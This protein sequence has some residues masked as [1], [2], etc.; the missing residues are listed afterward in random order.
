MKVLAALLLSLSLPGSHLASPPRSPVDRPRT[1]Q[2][3]KGGRWYFA[4]NGHAVYC[5]GP[6]MMVTQAQGGLQRVAT[7]CQGNKPMV[8]LKD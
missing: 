8:P 2:A 5:Y 1:Q 4:E 3:R 6:V 7:F